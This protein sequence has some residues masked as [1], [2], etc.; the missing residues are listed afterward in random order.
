MIK[1]LKL[2][3]ILLSLTALFV[4]L[5]VI[6]TGMNVINYRSVVSEAD[7]I[8]AL[9]SGNKGKF[10]D[11]NSNVPDNE[12]PAP[13]KPDE[14]KKPSHNHLP[15]HMSPELPY[16]SR[17]FSVLLTDDGRVLQ[18]DT[19]KIVSVDKP[20]AERL[21]VKV[22]SDNEPKGFMGQYRFIKTTED[23]TK[24]VRV[25]FL[26]CGRSLDSFKTFLWTSIMIALIGFVCVS[27]FI[28]FLSGKI[29]RPIS[30]SYEKQKRFITD[31]GHEIKTPLT[32]INANVDVLEME[33]G[34]NESL[35]D[36]HH[37]T[38]R[39]THLTNRLIALS[40]IE[41]ESSK[42]ETSTVC[43]SRIV[44]E[45]SEPFKAVALTQKKELVCDVCEDLILD[46]NEI[47]IG[48]LVSI[49]LDNAIKYSPSGSSVFL[50]LSKQARSVVLSVTN[51]TSLPIE[52]DR[53]DR[54]FDRF[55]RTDSSRNSETG[56]HGIG[57]SI[58]YAIVNAHGGKIAASSS[59]G[60]DFNI[61]ASFPQ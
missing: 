10:P 39:L 21:A 57:L 23:S 48:E 29:I 51:R 52:K 28:C 16:E 8:L 22:F 60:S 40:R 45:I 27:C 12:N 42:I 38:K 5:A 32:I 37:Q 43:V 20:S 34:E 6:V 7:D 36:I 35:S 53:I 54:V 33:F 26:D 4:L 14:T 17:Y 2:K 15:Q 1:K 59:S 25:T 41:E 49:L 30:E 55:Y 18:T 44:A 19:S 61:T 13:G 9:L 46:C 56:G 24:T 3:F 47:Q 31:A 50:K 11:E 58:A